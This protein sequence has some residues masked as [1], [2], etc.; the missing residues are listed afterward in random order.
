MDMNVPKDAEGNF[1]SKKF[2]EN[3]DAGVYPTTD[4]DGLCDAF[5]EY[6]EEILKLSKEMVA[7]GCAYCVWGVL[8]ARHPDVTHDRLAKH[9][10]AKDGIVMMH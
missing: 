1:D 2:I 7:C 8:T 5:P 3:M 6:R 10:N 4:V 9:F